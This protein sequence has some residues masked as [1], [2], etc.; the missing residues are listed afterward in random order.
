MGEAVEEA[1]W[2]EVEVVEGV[3]G[4]EGVLRCD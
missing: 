4:E 3:Q 1:Q 2:M